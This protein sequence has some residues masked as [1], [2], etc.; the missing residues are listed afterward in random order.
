VGDLFQVGA[1]GATLAVLTNE[2]DQDGDALVISSVGVAS[3]GTVTTDGAA[4]TYT[5][6]NSFRGI[7]ELTYTISDARGGS[8]TA[9]VTVR[10]DYPVVRTLAMKSD[11]VPGGEGA[12]WQRLGVPSIFKHEHPVISE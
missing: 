12:V 5:P 3:G 4:L 1:Q 9:K 7:D 10:A 2:S 6:S 11:E 8:A